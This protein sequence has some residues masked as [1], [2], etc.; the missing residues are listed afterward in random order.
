MGLVYLLTS[1][2]MVDL[3]GTC[4]EIYQS[5]GCCGDMF[6]VHMQCSNTFIK[7]NLYTC[8]AIQYSGRIFAYWCL[9]TKTGIGNLY[10][11]V[12]T[13]LKSVPFDAISLLVMLSL[14]VTVQSPFSGEFR[15]SQPKNLHLLTGCFWQLADVSL[16]VTVFLCWCQHIN[17]W[18]F[19]TSIVDGRNPKQPAGM[20]KT[21]Q[22]HGTNYLSTG[23]ECFFH[24][25]YGLFNPL[26]TQVGIAPY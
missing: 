16:E 24:Q 4:R 20:D 21:M 22:N 23:G 11:N 26:T 19:W 13:I 6:I 15:K 17:S 10:Y 1:T 8:G 12:G 5:H 18:E 3:Y 25:P 7:S 9:Y 2:W 14:P